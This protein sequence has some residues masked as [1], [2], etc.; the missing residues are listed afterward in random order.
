MPAPNHDY[1]SQVSNYWYSVWYPDVGTQGQRS[2]NQPMA[3]TASFKDKYQVGSTRTAGFKTTKRSLLPWNPYTKQIVI[4]RDPMALFVQKAKVSNGYYL[5]YYNSNASG[6]NVYSDPLSWPDTLPDFP[7]QKVISKLIEQCKLGRAQ[8]GVAAAEAYK[9]ATHL[10]HTAER[11]V[12]A[13]RALKSCRFGDFTSALGV[14]ATRRQTNRFYTGMR[15]SSGR[16][17]EGFRYNKRFTASYEAQK[18]S[19]LDFMSKTWLEYTY[20]WKPLIQDTYD[21]AKA[22]AEIFVDHSGV[23]RV[24][25]ARGKVEL[26]KKWNVDPGVTFHSHDSDCK[27]FL[28]MVVEYRIPSGGVLYSGVSASQDQSYF[29]LNIARSLFSTFPSFGWPR[30]K[31]PSSV[32]H[33]ASALALLQSLFTKDGKLRL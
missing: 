10:M 32:N 31:N 28:E 2:A 14:T 15:K 26:A 9:T 4:L 11:L 5:E 13:L 17:G 18:S 21:H 19:Y 24:A 7:T 6:L 1:F 16:K 23:W 8:T 25:K 29:E 20:G 30:L 12:K 27:R 22:F 3:T 33:A